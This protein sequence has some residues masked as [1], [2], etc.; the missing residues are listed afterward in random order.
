MS[1]G[2]ICC[3]CG[4]LFRGFGNN[5]WPLSDNPND[6]CCDDCNATRVIP[7]RIDRMCTKDVEAK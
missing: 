4:R 7:A 2:E 3:L 6:R 1:N 5:P